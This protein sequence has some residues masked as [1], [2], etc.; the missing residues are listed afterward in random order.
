LSMT[1]LAPIAAI[2]AHERQ[3]FD[4][5]LRRGVCSPWTTSAGRLFDA[6]AAILGL[7]SQ[8]SFEG[9]AAIAVESAATR[10]AQAYPLEAPELRED[11]HMLTADWRPMLASLARATEEQVPAGALARGFH[12]AL[13][14][15][16]VA[17][18]RR[19]GIQCVLLTGG[20][21]QNALLVSGAIE[22]LRLAG[23]DVR[24]HHQVP[25]NDDGLAVGQAAFALRPL[26]EE[27]D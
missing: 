19:I 17:V 16:I 7:C 21:F 14:E 25:P 2:T 4:T 10:T 6:A 18:V 27:K 23:F 5:M 8:S 3:L 20:C 15:L 11:G 24:T 1:S 13:A 12:D 9:E 22:R 26:L